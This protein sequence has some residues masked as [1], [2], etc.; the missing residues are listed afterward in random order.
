[1]VQDVVDQVSCQ[2]S[3]RESRSLKLGML[4]QITLRTHIMLKGGNGRNRR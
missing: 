1:M 3:N 2:K 4:P